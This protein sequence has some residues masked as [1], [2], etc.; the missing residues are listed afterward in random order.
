MPDSIFHESIRQGI[1]YFFCFVCLFSFFAGRWNQFYRY[2]ISGRGEIL[3]Y[4]G[5]SQMRLISLQWDSKSG[6]CQGISDQKLHC[7]VHLSLYGVLFLTR[8]AAFL[9]NRICLGLL[10]MNSNTTLNPGN[11]LLI[12]WVNMTYQIEDRYL[13]SIH[14]WDSGPWYVLYFPLLLFFCCIL[15]FCYFLMI[16][17]WVTFVFC[18]CFHAS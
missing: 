1:T 11:R 17:C 4:N 2:N 3:S 8:F 18:F 7:G 9:F 13:P 12:T 5:L 6:T 14:F 15:F 16:F 10:R